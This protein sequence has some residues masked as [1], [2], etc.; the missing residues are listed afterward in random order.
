MSGAEESEEGAPEA[1]RRLRPR[2]SNICKLNRGH[3]EL[4]GAT[5]TGDSE[6]FN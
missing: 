1:V 6:P 2:P 5:A 3:E 4:P